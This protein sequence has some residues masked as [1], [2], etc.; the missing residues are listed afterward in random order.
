MNETLGGGEYRMSW[1]LFRGGRDAHRM[2]LGFNF[3][4]VQD[5]QFKKAVGLNLRI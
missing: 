2:G 5:H 1:G 4:D 3:V